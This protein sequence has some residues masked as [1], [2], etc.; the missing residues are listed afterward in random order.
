ML[1]AL[2]ATGA[3]DHARPTVAVEQVRMLS[4][5]PKDPAP[6]ELATADR[7]LPGRRRSTSTTANGTDSAPPPSCSA[8][9]AT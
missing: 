9:T 5:F 4:A 8:P 7:V 1:A 3:L 6:T 2:S